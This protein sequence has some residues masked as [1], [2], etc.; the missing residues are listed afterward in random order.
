MP[1][2]HWKIKR[3]R[4]P[5]PLVGILG[6][7]GLSRKGFKQIGIRHKHKYGLLSFPTI[8]FQS[9]NILFVKTLNHI[10]PIICHED[11][12][13]IRIFSCLAIL[14]HLLQAFTIVRDQVHVENTFYGCLRGGLT[15]GLGVQSTG[16][17]HYYRH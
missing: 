8:F 9:L 2:A 1:T 3:S 13:N 15:S 12:G 6:S 14:I 16:I 4:D 10:N 5:Q 17:C 7:K 11:E